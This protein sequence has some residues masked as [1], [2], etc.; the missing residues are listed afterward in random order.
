MRYSR[1]VSIRTGNYD[2]TA[3]QNLRQRGAKTIIAY[4]IE[5]FLSKSRGG[6]CEGLMTPQLLQSTND[7]RSISATHQNATETR[8]PSK[9]EAEIRVPERL[10]AQ[11]IAFFAFLD[12]LNISWIAKTVPRKLLRSSIQRYAA[13]SCLCSGSR[14]ERTRSGRGLGDGRL[15]QRNQP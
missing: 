7:Q 5:D 10:K 4:E 12:V 13:Q 15:S 8:V 2:Q 1:V 11:L 3:K 14:A 6:N 9:R